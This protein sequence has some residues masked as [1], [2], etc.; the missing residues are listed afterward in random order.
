MALTIRTTKEIEQEIKEIKK[1]YHYK[2]ASKV[3]INS[4]M[5]YRINIDLI[6]KL[7][8]K[9]IELI[10]KLRELRLLLRQQYQVKSKIEE[11]VSS[12]EKQLELF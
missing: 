3:V 5:T 1:E 7:E 8:H 4:V 11:I 9:N 6:E 12:A 2:A 10:E